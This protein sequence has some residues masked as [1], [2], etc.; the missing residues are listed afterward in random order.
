[1]AAKKTQHPSPKSPVVVPISKTQPAAEPTV[2]LMSERW[3]AVV[4]V[5]A[6]GI[7]LSL[8]VVTTRLVTKQLVASSDDASAEA[9][10]S[11][12]AI[13][14]SD[15]LEA[16]PEIPR[17]NLRLAIHKMRESSV[18]APVAPAPIVS[19]TATGAAQRMQTPVLPLVPGDDVLSDRLRAGGIS[20][21]EPE[22]VVALVRAVCADD[23][24]LFE[25]PKK[26]YDLIQKRLRSINEPASGELLR[27]RK[28]VN[29]RK[30]S[31]IIDAMSDVDDIAINEE[32]RRELLKSARETLIPGLWNYMRG[33]LIWR[34]EALAAAQMSAMPM[35]NQFTSGA[36]DPGL[37]A[38]VGASSSINTAP[39]VDGV[40]EVNDTVNKTFRGL[41]VLAAISLLEQ[42]R[43]A[44]ELMSNESLRTLMG[45]TT[46]EEALR[47]LGVNV[48][49]N[50]QRDERELARFTIAAMNLP[51]VDSGSEM[52]YIGQMIAS[53]AQVNWT[54]FGVNTNGDEDELLGTKH[55]R[56]ASPTNGFGASTFGGNASSPLPDIGG[57]RRES[58]GSTGQR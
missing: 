6:S 58:R 13:P 47:L 21:V 22:H 30:F 38:L 4:G 54:R 28:L 57:A 19:A 49:I 50:D 40:A 56:T 46:Q 12:A 52:A 23:A 3:K 29:R 48:G 34:R 2:K 35:F 16:F 11:A 32:D 44:T 9:L 15:L 25:L 41:G 26:I 39:V 14:D 36:V 18:P 55:P 33:L 5:L 10:A 31:S 20:K 42:V 1:M 45:V 17:G 37:I 53:G 43:H 24:G 27:L 8:D 51:R 7:N